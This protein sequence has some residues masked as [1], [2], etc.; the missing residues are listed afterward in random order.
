MWSDYFLFLLKTL[1]FLIAFIV[2]VVVIM[3]GAKS[4]GEL[5]GKGRLIT[6]YLNEQWDKLTL[7][8]Q[9]QLLDKK[10]FKALVKQQK[11]EKKELE[12]DDL[13]TRKKAFSI[14]FKGDMQAS[15]VESL[16][17][18][19]TAILLVAKPGDRVVVNIESPGGAVAGYGLAAA[20]LSRLKQAELE[21]VACVDKVA[22]SGGYMMACIADKIV[23]APF[24]FIGSIGVLSQVP[25][26]HRLLKRY[27]V[28]V[29]VM[30]AGKH[31]APIT[32]LG[33]NTED[34]KKKH[35]EDLNAIHKRFKG[36][37]SSN[38]PD[39]D[40]EAVAEGDFWLAEDALEHKLVDEL[41]TSDDYL[42]ALG[43]EYEVYRVQWVPHK[44]LEEKVKGASAALFDSVESAI[45][46]KWLP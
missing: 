6:V 5:P 23:A 22:A 1:T 17:R 26:V 37:V 16:R 3:R 7:A 9:Q 12:K 45:R 27:D 19:V 43:R 29:D 42:Q 18:E 30:T 39:V 10:A 28:D 38:R 33:E 8:L 44:S 11:N 4:G 46:K 36:L 25:N 34:G 40:I 20:Q 14:I 2:M 13:T 21:L 35:I 31:K 32:F 15:Q 24:A 41:M